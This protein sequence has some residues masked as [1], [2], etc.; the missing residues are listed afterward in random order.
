MRVLVI[1]LFLFFAT[2]AVARRP[3]FKRSL[4]VRNGRNEKYTGTH[5]HEGK[6]YKVHYNVTAHK[7][8]LSLDLDEA[9]ESVVCLADEIRVTFSSSPPNVTAYVVGRVLAGGPE[10]GCFNSQPFLRRIVSRAWLGS[11]V[12]SL[13]VTNA[14]LTDALTSASI[15][16]D[17]YAD[18]G[19]G[20]SRTAQAPIL[21]Q[22]T[23]FGPRDGVHERNPPL[24]EPRARVQKRSFPAIAVT[25]P[26]A[27]SSYQVGAVS[28]FFVVPP[29]R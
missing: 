17:D 1:A 8:L 16:M 14:T 19:Q 5:Q 18:V 2:L 6:T 25:S 11:V 26:V 10:W 7:D 24:A 15:N 20:A 29:W 3:A 21:L 12:L 28:V 9:V 4:G 27:G 13:N 23:P 22:G